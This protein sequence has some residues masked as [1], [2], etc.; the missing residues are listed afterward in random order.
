MFALHEGW[1]TWG[2]VPLV[3]PPNGTHLYSHCGRRPVTESE[4]VF[5]TPEV[6]VVTHVHKIGGEETLRD[7]LQNVALNK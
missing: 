6:K 5:L 2:D 7:D 3:S 1:L 4:A